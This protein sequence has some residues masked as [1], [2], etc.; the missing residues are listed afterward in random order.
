MRGRNPG[1]TFVL[2]LQ[3]EEFVRDLEGREDGYSRH[4]VRRD[5]RGRLAHSGIDE[6][7][8]PRGALPAVGR[9]HPVGL[10]ED[11]DVGGRE[12]PPPAAFISHSP[13]APALIPRPLV[14]ALRYALLSPFGVL[15]T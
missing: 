1:F 10:V 4:V 8:D 7:R 6:P 14:P 3:Q 12:I 2:L 11:R 5:L 9:G 15:P 13:I